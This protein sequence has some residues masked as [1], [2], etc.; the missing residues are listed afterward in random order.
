MEISL[1]SLF[2]SILKVQ[3]RKYCLYNYHTN[4]TESIYKRL[5]LYNRAKNICKIYR[6]KI[7]N[8]LHE[9]KKIALREGEYYI[10]HLFSQLGRDTFNSLWVEAVVEPVCVCPECPVSFS[11]GEGGEKGVSVV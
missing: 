8:Q 10:V 6:I 9:S 7:S 3:K 4:Y 2:S 1:A 11:G 5:N